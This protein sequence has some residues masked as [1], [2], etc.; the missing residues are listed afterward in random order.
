MLENMSSLPMPVVKIQEPRIDI[1]PRVYFANVGGSNITQ[2]EIN[3]T[4]SSDQQL[5]FT[6]T[7]PST[8]VFMSR[9]I[10][11]EYAMKV[12]FHAA[13]G[14]DIPAVNNLITA[15][16]RAFPLSS[17]TET[18]TLKLNNLQLM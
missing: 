18:L 10:Y 16:L 11:V 2:Q 7:T 3:A 5:I 13:K 12:T 4:T 15:G 1:E 8:N 9:R 14:G 17:S 6:T